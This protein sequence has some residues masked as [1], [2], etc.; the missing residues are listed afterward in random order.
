MNQLCSSG[1]HCPFEPVGK[2]EHH[3]FGSLPVPFENLEDAF[4]RMASR[5]ENRPGMR[6]HKGLSKGLPATRPGVNEEIRPDVRKPEVQVYDLRDS[7]EEQMKK[8]N[9]P[10]CP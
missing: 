2:I 9:V 3:F 10:L 5:G 6:G 7:E 8:E 1:Q 4:F